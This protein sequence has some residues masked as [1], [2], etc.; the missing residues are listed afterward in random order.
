M[1]SINYQP[2]DQEKINKIL[3]KKLVHSISFIKILTR[4]Q[5]KK[6]N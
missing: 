6:D 3:R 4:I 5:I 1:D 2:K